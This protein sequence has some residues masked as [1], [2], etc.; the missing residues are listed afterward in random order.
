MYASES[1][2]D[3]PDILGYALDQHLFQLTHPGYEQEYLKVS[4]DLQ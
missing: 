1:Q 4:N 2:T 3:N